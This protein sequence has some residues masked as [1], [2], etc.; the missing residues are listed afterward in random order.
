MTLLCPFLPISP[1]LLENEQLRLWV[2]LFSNITSLQDSKP[3]NLGECF[4]DRK[5]S[6]AFLTDV[7]LFG[8]CFVFLSVSMEMLKYPFHV[9]GEDGITQDWFLLT[10][11][12]HT[13]ILLWAASNA[14][15]CFNLSF[16]TELCVYGILIKSP[17]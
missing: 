6:L 12:K 3:E 15:C 7:F 4:V 2:R 14:S 1:W 13:R 16:P 17:Y 10:F 11:R 5:L 8:C 9:C